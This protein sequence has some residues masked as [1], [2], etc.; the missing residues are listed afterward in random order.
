[1]PSVIALEND[2]R[3]SMA[4]GPYFTFFNLHTFP[5]SSTKH[6]GPHALR[7]ATCSPVAKLKPFGCVYQ[8]LFC[9]SLTSLHI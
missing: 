1:M 4:V 2:N 3:F 8:C 6:T 9:I 7:S 5:Y